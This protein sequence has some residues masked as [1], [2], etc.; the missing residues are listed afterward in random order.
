MIRSDDAD[1][2]QAGAVLVK[3]EE[4]ERRVLLVTNKEKSR[5]IF[6]KGTVK[7]KETEEEAAAREAEEETGVRGHV[8]AYIGAVESE[9]DD[10]LVRVD[11]FLLAVDEE[12]EP[13]EDRFVRWCTPDEVL[14]LVDTP[15]LNGLM[16]Q[17]LPEI[18]EFKL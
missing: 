18:A 1:K 14:E 6:P 9:E 16:K 10:K 11:Y 2:P 17:A 12:S 5:W 7:K 15:E 13:S 4:E 3:G 8:V